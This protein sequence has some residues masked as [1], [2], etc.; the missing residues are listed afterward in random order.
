MERLGGYL[1]GDRFQQRSLLRFATPQAVEAGLPLGQIDL[2]AGEAMRPQWIDP[3]AP[4]QQFGLAL[5]VTVFAQ[6]AGLLEW[7]AESDDEVFDPGGGRRR[8]PPTATGSVGPIDA[9]PAL[10]VGTPDPELDGAQADVELSGH[11]A[12][13]PALPHGGHQGPALPF[14]VVFRS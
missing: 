8:G 4:P 5:L 9:V 13:R 6:G 12:Q 3:I 14:L 10:A 7:L 1:V 2:G 11:G